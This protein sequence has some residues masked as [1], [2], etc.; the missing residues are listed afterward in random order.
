MAVLDK[1][2]IVPR[3][4][5]LL[6]VGRIVKNRGGHSNGNKLGTLLLGFEDVVF[7]KSVSCS[8]Y[9]KVYFHF[10]EFYSC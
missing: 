3:G 5:T 7:L 4:T 2:K 9:T 10:C 8:F 1:D 6:S